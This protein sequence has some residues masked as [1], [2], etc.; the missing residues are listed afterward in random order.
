MDRHS[1]S[2]ENVEK[3]INWIEERGGVAIWRSI[4]L[5]NPGKSWSSPALNKDG[6]PTTK[7]SW[8]CGNSPERVITSAADI[9]VVTEIEVKRF[10][11][12]VRRGAQGMMLKLTDASTRRVRAACAKAEETAKWSNYHF[13]METQEVIITVPSDIVPLD[14]W[15]EEHD[16]K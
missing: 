10:R 14:K 12:A 4:N 13:D 3:F 16:G 9:D 2:I 6:T 15:M 1:C 11:I 8:E 5:S 7:P